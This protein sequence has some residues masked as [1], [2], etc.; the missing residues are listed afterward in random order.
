MTAVI[1]FFL[2]LAATTGGVLLRSC[3]SGLEANFERYWCGPQP[4]ALLAQSHAHC[5]GC[6]VLA[7]GF[8]LMISA[9]VVGGL[10]RRRAVREQA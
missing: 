9:I 7:F 10:P 6:E 2:G 5:A 1:I 4:H 3:N 8:I